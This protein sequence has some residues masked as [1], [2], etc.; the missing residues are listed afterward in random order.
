MI[1]KKKA[2]AG[3]G[4]KEKYGLGCRGWQEEVVMFDVKH[5]PA[6]LILETEDRAQSDPDGKVFLQL[7]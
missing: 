1:K 5:F 4:A 2:D 7:R 3:K 6:A